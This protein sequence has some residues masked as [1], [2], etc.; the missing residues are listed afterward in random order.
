MDAREMDA[1]EL[2][3]KLY[4][5]GMQKGIRVLA[6]SEKLASAEELAIMST[7]EVCELIVQ[8]YI[9]LFS[10][11]EELGLVKKDDY[12]EILSKIRVISRDIINEG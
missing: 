8:K 7:I 3:S 5:T 4:Y 9:V 6:L 11:N 1:R 2:E 12:E 10:N